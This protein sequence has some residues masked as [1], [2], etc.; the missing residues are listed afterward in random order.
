MNHLAAILLLCTMVLLFAG[1][2]YELDLAAREALVPALGN[3][4]ER[5]P[6]VA[7]ALLEPEGVTEKGSIHRHRALQFALVLVLVALISAVLAR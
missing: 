6:A 2:L 1:L 3:P 7:A 4:L 5:L